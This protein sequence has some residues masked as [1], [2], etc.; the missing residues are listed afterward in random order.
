MSFQTFRTRPYKYH[1]VGGTNNVPKPRDYP[2][3]AYFV[4]ADTSM[5]SRSKVQMNDG[6]GTDLF[7][8]SK[9]RL[10]KGTFV[11][12]VFYSS[13]GGYPTGYNEDGS[14]FAFKDIES[15]KKHISLSMTKLRDS[16][17]YTI[18]FP[19]MDTI[20]LR[21]Q[22]QMQRVITDWYGVN[23]NRFGDPIEVVLEDGSYF[24]Y[25]YGIYKIMIMDA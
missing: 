5:A 14:L 8:R 6:N 3:G 1:L 10:K 21:S 4:S 23:I 19:D 2:S 15:A 25:Y 7:F 20:D 18:T 11:F 9:D 17:E 22:Y 16:S 12:V 13:D 24:N